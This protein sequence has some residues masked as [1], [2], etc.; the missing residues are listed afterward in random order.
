M[1]SAAVQGLW[2]YFSRMRE[3]SSPPLPKA[4]GS[5]LIDSCHMWRQDGPFVEKIKKHRMAKPEKRP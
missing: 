3:G 2:C 4:D 5:M 1:S